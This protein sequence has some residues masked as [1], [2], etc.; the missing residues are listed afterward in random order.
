M[1]RLSDMSKYPYCSECRQRFIIAYFGQQ[2]ENWQ[3]DSCDICLG[4]VVVSSRSY[5]EKSRRIRNDAKHALSA[6]KLELYNQLRDLRNEMAEEKSV[7]PYQI[8]SNQALKGLAE[9]SPVS[10]REAKKLKGIGSK[11]EWYLPEF[12]KVISSWRKAQL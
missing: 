5:K 12:L 2:I 6:D 7:F 1:G 8:F 11:N 10:I 3:C 4:E 9:A